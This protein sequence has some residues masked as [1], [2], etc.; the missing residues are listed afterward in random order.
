MSAMPG[1]RRRKSYTH[2]WKNCPVLEI[3]RM[4]WDMQK[5]LTT[6]NNI[7]KKIK[8]LLDITSKSQK[9]SE[10][11][12]MP[13]SKKREVGMLVKGRETAEENFF[14]FMNSPWGTLDECSFYKITPYYMHLFIV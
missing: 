2:Y 1:R 7:A 11:D 13:L 14:C 9:H 3:W 4:E 12:G 6:K 5:N 10:R 8:S